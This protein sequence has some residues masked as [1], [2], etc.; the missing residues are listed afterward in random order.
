MRKSIGIAL[1][2]FFLSFGYSIAQSNIVKVIVPYAPGGNVDNIARVYSK[3][4]SEKFNENW[5]VENISGANGVIGAS[6]VAKSK[7]DGRTLLFSADVHSMASLVIKYVPYDAINDFIPIS[8]V[9]KAPLIFVVN[10]DSVR[11]GNL[12]QL[13]DEIKSNPEK[14]NFA[15]SGSGSSP[16]LGAEI[17]KSKTNLPLATIN[18][19]G[20]G[21]AVTDLAGGHVNLM[22]VTPLAVMPLIKAGKLRALAVT[23]KNRFLP[24]PDIPS[25]AESGMPGFELENSYGF[26]GPKGVPSSQ[27]MKISQQLKQVSE[28]A[29]LQKRLLELG[30]NASWESSEDTVKHI[31]REFKRNKEIY[32]KANVKP[33]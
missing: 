16:Q 17:F 32:L 7:P 9:A 5:I 11:A 1:I 6:H 26:W 30:V 14:Y 3:F 20:T 10:P 12:T 2:F 4:I 21:P 29:E 33:E 13:I 18:Y 22:V 8:L 27:I 24:L 23:S 25:T 19:R 28:D 31:A 15:I